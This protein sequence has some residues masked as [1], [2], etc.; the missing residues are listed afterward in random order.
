MSVIKIEQDK[1]EFD[2]FS[3]QVRCDIRF[4]ES[5][6][7]VMRAQN[8]PNEQVI[9]TYEMMLRNRKDVLARLQDECQTNLKTG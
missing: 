7:S 6:L 3:H 5:R 1:P 4:L 8:N 2:I 9:R